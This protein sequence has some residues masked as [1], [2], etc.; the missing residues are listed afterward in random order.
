M[1]DN[2]AKTAAVKSINLASDSFLGLVQCAK[3]N[4]Q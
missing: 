2:Q 3:D 1:I 4:T